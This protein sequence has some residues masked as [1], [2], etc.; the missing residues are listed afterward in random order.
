MAKSEFA[1]YL[2]PKAI[3]NFSVIAGFLMFIIPTLIFLGK[4]VDERASTLRVNRE[5]VGGES[6][7]IARLAS[8]K[9][10]SAEAEAGLAV[11]QKLIPPRDRLFSFPDY[12]EEKGDASRVTVNFDFAGG[13]SPSGEGSAGNSPFRIA[14]TGPFDNI[15]RYIES[16]ENSNS[17]FVK[18]GAV[19][20]TREGTQFS[21]GIGGLVYFYE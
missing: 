17:F 15:V 7:T 1:K 20:F 19:D 4:E 3:I 8:L 14:S 16:I 10:A 11:M 13:E 2:T 5:K 12:L 9:S 18:L 21:S 6:S